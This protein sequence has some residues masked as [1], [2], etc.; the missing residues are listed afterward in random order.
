MPQKANPL[1]GLSVMA[2]PHIVLIRSPCKTKTAQ[3][4][5]FSFWSD[6]SP[7]HGKSFDNV[8]LKLFY[9]QEA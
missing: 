6:K 2:K 8:S 4:F 7:F 5:Q 1:T 9:G 3:I